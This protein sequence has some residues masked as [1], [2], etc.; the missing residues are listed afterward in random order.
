[1]RNTIGRVVTLVL[2]TALALT[3]CGGSGPTDTVDDFMRA[4]R[5][6]DI[7]QLDDLLRGEFR[8]Q[9]FGV[10]AQYTEYERTDT[11]NRIDIISEDTYDG[12]PARARVLTRRHRTLGEWYEE[13]E[14]VM[15]DRTYK[16]V[17]RKTLVGPVEYSDA[18]PSEDAVAQETGPGRTVVDFIRALEQGAGPG[19]V[20]GF[21]YI[22]GS[23]EVRHLEKLESD[24]GGMM[25]KVRALGGSAEE[26][27]VVAECEAKF[28]Q[29]TGPN[30]EWL[31]LLVEVF[32]DNLIG[33]MYEDA[34]SF[35]FSYSILSEDIYEGSEVQARVEVEITD[36]G[37]GF[38]GLLIEGEV[39]TF[40]L[41]MEDG[42]WRITTLGFKD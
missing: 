16:I 10:F 21:V 5:R 17:N 20:A 38:E 25:A 18:L 13:F 24:C 41:V 14:L 33:G 29:L 31:D 32:G 9:A 2:A 8:E 15:Q 28:E 11:P 23:E 39:I 30:N 37:D 42:L 12:Q 26:L 19:Q 27:E 1:M 22:L 4:W 7:Q 40:G 3:A 34:G 6:I 36:G 35:D